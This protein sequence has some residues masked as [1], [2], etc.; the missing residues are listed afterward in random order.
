MFRELI[1]LVQQ[2]LQGGPAFK[3][4]GFA[5]ISVEG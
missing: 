3:V 1:Q 4:K 2:T 5:G